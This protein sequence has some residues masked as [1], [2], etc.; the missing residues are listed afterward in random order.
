MH[1]YASL[2]QEPVGNRGLLSSRECGEQPAHFLVR[3]LPLRHAHVHTDIYAFQ[4]AGGMAP[5]K[6]REL[7]I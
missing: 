5:L 4:S 7:D 2:S 3:P 6:Q 1:T